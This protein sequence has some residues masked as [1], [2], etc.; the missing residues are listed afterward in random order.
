MPLNVLVLGNGGRECA[1][2]WKIAHSPELGKLFIM[3]GNPGTASFARNL[4]GNAKDFAAIK[5]EVSENKID[6]LVVG[7]EDPLVEG[8]SDYF[9]AEMPSLKVI[10]PGKA[11][12]RL[13]E[14]HDPPRNP[15]GTIQKFRRL[16]HVARSIG[17]PPHHEAALRVES[18][19]LGSR[20][21]RRD[22]Q[23]A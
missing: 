11:G 8:I 7:P 6:L 20:K 13:K 9:A 19:R 14:I 4:E 15:Y 1:L 23:Y 10:G 21:G 3:N 12:A 17:F 2:A 5:S 16:F 22:C 18:G